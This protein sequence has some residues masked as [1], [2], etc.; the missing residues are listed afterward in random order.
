M[1]YDKVDNGQRAILIKYGDLKRENWKLLKRLR[2]RNL[3][4]G[5]S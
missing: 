2:K 3:S 1:K 4:S 5:K